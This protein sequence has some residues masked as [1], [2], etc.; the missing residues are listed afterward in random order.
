MSAQAA[1]VREAGPFTPL[2]AA[3]IVLVGVFAFCVLIVLGTYAPDLHNGD[4][5]GAHA[6]SRSAVGFAG[7]AEALRLAGEP[8]LVS[9][10]ALPPGRHAGVL[11]VTPPLGATSEAI[12]AL[13]FG[14]PVLVVLPKWLGAPEQ[15]HR[16]WVTKVALLDARWAPPGSLVARA[17]LA[18]RQGVSRPA[19]HAVSGPLAVGRSLTFGPVESL[20]TI[21]G[22]GW[23]PVLTDEHGG[24]VLARDPKGPAFVLA[25]PDLLNNQG[26][27]NIATFAGGLA[28][29]DALRARAGPVIFDVTLDGLGKEKGILR[30]AFDPPFLAVTLCLAAAAALA[31]FQAFC[32]FG[33]VRAGGRALALGKEALADNTAALVRLAG[34]EARMGGRYAALTR[35]LAAKAVG[36]PRD[37][38]EEDLTRL[39]DRLGSRRGATDTLGYLTVMARVARDRAHLMDAARRLYHWRLEMTR[40]RS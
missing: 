4:D 34:R 14:G 33:P 11:V 17:G 7:L 26:L 37:L 10:H 29:I 31:G 12:A 35:D 36:A 13:R 6:L 19:L 20:Q 1:D 5:G 27:G 2:T 18:R 25:D 15:K 40:E 21:T 22:K 23:I 30:L 32:R 28:I 16:G 8:V 3:V 9:R 39:L 24:V 38:G